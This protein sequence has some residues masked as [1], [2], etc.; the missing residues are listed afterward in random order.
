MQEKELTIDIAQRVAAQLQAQGYQV[1]MTRSD[2]RFVN[3][4][5]RVGIANRNFAD[6]F[7][8][9]HANGHPNS[10]INGVETHFSSLSPKAQHLA[11]QIQ[12]QLLS[13]TNSRDR[14]LF[15]SNFFVLRHTTMPAVI[16]E[17]GY[18]T[19]EREGSLLNTNDYREK[20][21]SG[22]TKGIMNY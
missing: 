1:I 6:V 8:S 18:V 16:V 11:T 21:A 9:I 4:F 22:I 13:H 14:G 17:V 10:N 20:I 7:V 3:L 19:N 5:E 12:T 15:D 2:D